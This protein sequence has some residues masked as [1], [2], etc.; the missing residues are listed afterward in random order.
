MSYEFYK[1]VHFSGIFA[2]IMGVC[3]MIFSKA[4]DVKDPGTKKLF[5]ILHGLG[6]LVAL[7]GGFGLIAKLQSGFPAW[8]FLKLVFWLGLGLLPIL[9]KFLQ[10]RVTFTLGILLAIGAATVAVIKPLAGA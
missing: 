4:Y 9:G 3:G 10:A 7:V 5:G 6:L 1:I 2:L 8:I